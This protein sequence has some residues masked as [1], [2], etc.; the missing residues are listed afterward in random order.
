M[1]V[2]QKVLETEFSIVNCRSTG[3]IWQS[4]TLS[5]VIFDPHSLIIKLLR[6]HSFQKLL[7]AWNF[8]CM[9]KNVFY[10]GDGYLWPHCCINNLH[11]SHRPLYTPTYS[12]WAIHSMLISFSRVTSWFDTVSNVVSRWVFDCRLSGVDKEMPQSHTT[13][14]PM[15]LWGRD[16]RTQSNKDKDTKSRI[17]S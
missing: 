15:T 1:Y 8:S 10:R 11:I 12:F 3:E 2:D 9:N 4:K 14:Q 6:G 5:I 7:L 17:H 13:N 16:I